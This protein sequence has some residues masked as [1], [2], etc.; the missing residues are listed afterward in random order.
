[1]KIGFIGVGAMGKPMAQN[2]LKADYQ[3]YVYDLI[4][5]NVQQLS[6]QGAISCSS[7]NEVATRADLIITSLPNAKIV[8]TVMTGPKGVIAACQP[9]SVIMDMSSVA[10]ETTRQMAKLAENRQVKYIDAPVSGGVAGAQAGTLTIMVG[11][12]VETFERIKPVLQVLGKNIYHVGAAGLGDAIKIVNNLLLGCNMAALAEA[13][14]LGVKC[15][16]T[17][18]IMQEV[19]KVSSGRSYAFEAKM[20]KFIL[21]DAFEGGFAV[22]LQFKDLG[23]AMDAGKDVSMPLP[24]TAAASQVFATARAKGLNRQDISSIIKVWE[25]LTGVSVRTLP[26]NIPE[27]M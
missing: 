25:D 16:L 15:G 10:P 4:A 22:D 18:E 7:G 19:I 1:M 21:A 6:E 9:G 27:K 12:D 20:E 14:V 17:P 3:V 2:L 13:L 24:I 23:L 11:S 8:E 5:A 26:N